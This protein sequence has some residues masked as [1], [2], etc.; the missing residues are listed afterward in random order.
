MTKP[1]HGSSARRSPTARYTRSTN[2][3]SA[4][5][6]S[7]CANNR[8][9]PA[10][11]TNMSPGNVVYI[12]FAGKTRQCEHGQR[13]RQGEDADVHPSPDGQDENQAE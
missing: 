9:T 7:R 1:A 10:M 3:A 4:P 12:V 2:Q 5:L 13:R 8:D 11:S 6:R